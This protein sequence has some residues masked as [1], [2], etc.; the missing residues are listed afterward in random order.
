MGRLNWT[1][2]AKARNIERYGPTI[3]AV[4]EQPKKKRRKKRRGLLPR[5]AGGFAP[6]ERASI[7]PTPVP[8]EL[9]Q[10]PV[11]PPSKAKQRSVAGPRS[12]SKLVVRE[13]R[14]IDTSG[15]SRSIRISSK[16]G[17]RR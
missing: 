12:A 11:Q 7:A 10:H 16:S 15:Q 8:K 3:T 4:G 14:V 1:T 9:A 5:V 2:V 13:V 6:K 17:T